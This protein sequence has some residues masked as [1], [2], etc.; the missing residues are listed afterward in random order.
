MS[1]P[2]CDHCHLKGSVPQRMFTRAH[3]YYPV[4]PTHVAWANSQMVYSTK[5]AHPPMGPS[6]E[7]SPNV[8][9]SCEG[10][11]NFG[12]ICVSNMKLID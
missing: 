4:Y 10:V 7:G 11:N 2:P 8:W 12:T 1:P 5:K 3:D 6:G 9:I